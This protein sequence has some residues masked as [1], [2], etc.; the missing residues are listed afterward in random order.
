M[1]IKSFFYPRGRRNLFGVTPGKIFHVETLYYCDC[2]DG[3]TA[4]IRFQ[5][6]K[7]FLLPKCVAKSVDED[8]LRL[9][10]IFGE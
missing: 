5:L 9:E 4:T 7:I 6:L 8:E 1:P 2:C 10:L 3:I